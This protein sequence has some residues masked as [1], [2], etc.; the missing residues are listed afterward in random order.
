MVIIHHHRKKANDAQS[1]KQP[2]TLHDVYGSYI[3]T[4]TVD[5]VLNLEE[6]PD[7]VDEKTLTLSM[8]K[9]R[10][11]AVPEPVKVSRSEKL[12]FSVLQDIARKFLEGA[13]TDDNSSPAPSLTI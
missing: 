2:D 13:P 11:S 9:S 12:H 3:I 4:S 5:F 7:D 6:R 1:K 8:L 10:Y